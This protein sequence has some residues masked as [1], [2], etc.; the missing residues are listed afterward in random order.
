MQLEDDEVC[1]EDDSGS[2]RGT[3]ADGASDMVAAWGVST[4]CAAKAT[5][6]TRETRASFMIGFMG[7]VAQTGYNGLYIS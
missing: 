6:A 1:R 4:A 2:G 3:A 5:P 7:E